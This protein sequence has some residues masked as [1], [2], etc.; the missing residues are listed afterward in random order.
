ISTL[1][2]VPRL[3]GSGH[4]AGG[5]IGRTVGPTLADTGL[6]QLQRIVSRC[7]CEFYYASHEEAEQ[8]PAGDGWGAQTQPYDS[9]TL[10]HH[11]LDVCT[12]SLQRY[13]DL[14]S[15]MTSRFGKLLSVKSLKSDVTSP[16]SQTLT[17]YNF[18]I[19]D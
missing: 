15:R 12:N 11:D 10:M 19:F 1:P 5:V 2:D 4:S 3:V 7:A 16:Y 13:I 14:K 17:R 8:A 9:F 18:V 6:A